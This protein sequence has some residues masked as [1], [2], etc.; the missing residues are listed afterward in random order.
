MERSFRLAN[1]SF[2]HD[3]FAILVEDDVKRGIQCRCHPLEI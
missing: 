1:C 3:I 2:V